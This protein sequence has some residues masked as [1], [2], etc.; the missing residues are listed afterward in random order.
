MKVINR[1]GT[2]AAV[3]TAALLCGCV[4]AP[5]PG[6]G[7][8]VAYSAPPPLRYEV[9]GVAPAPGY[10]WIG[11]GWYWERGVYAWHPGR[12]A[13]PRPGYRWAP[14]AWRPVGNTWR[15]APGHWVRGYR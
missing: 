2:M 10:F 9:V 3:A 11:G 6:Y 1:G 7:E 5:A 4:V 12:W 15:M 14:Q 13:A 8:V